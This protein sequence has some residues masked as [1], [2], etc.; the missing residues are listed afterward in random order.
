MAH[1]FRDSTTF[2]KILISVN[3]WPCAWKVHAYWIFVS[4]IFRDLLVHHG[5]HEVYWPRIFGA[6]QYFIITCMCYI[7]A[8]ITSPVLASNHGN[9]TVMKSPPHNELV[10]SNLQELQGKLRLVMWLSHVCHMIIIILCTD[11]LKMLGIKW[12]SYKKWSECYKEWWVWLR[13]WYFVNINF[14]RHLQKNHQQRMN[15]PKVNHNQRG[16]VIQHSR[17][18]PL[19]HP[20]LI[21]LTNFKVWPYSNMLGVFNRVHVQWKLYVH[22]LGEPNRWQA[23]VLRAIVVWFIHVYETI[24]KCKRC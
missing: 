21:I 6:I 1:K 19:P 15:Y 11:K 22:L 7:A 2:C 20:Q 13:V 18:L 23:F 10:D 17:P 5:N 3:V 4:N 16:V 24:T 14:Y 8:T 12:K 9:S